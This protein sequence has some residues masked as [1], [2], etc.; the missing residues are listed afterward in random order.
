MKLLS[1]L[2]LGLLG[3]TCAQQFGESSQV[4]AATT[5]T[6]SSFLDDVN[7][8]LAQIESGEVTVG[9]SQGPAGIARMRGAAVP[10]PIL[11]QFAG[12]KLP[13]GIQLSDFAGGPNGF[14]TQAFLKALQAALRKQAEQQRLR[15]QQLAAQRQRE[16]LAA[17]AAKE[18]AEE[19]ARLKA[20]QEAKRLAAE[21]AA[22]EAEQAAAEEAARE[23][24]KQAAAEEAARQAAQ[25]A[26][27]AEAKRVA[28][29]KEQARQE[30]LREAAR[31]RA[32]EQA[33]AK[34]AEQAAREAA[35][36]AE[37]DAAMEAAGAS[38]LSD[39]I[40]S[41]M[42]DEEF[43]GS[44]SGRPNQGNSDGS[45][46]SANAGRPNATNSNSAGVRD[47]M[48]NTVDNG[49]NVLSEQDQRFNSCRVCDKMTA[50]ECASQSLTQCGPT[51]DNLTDN[52]VC[53]LTLDSRLNKDGT[54]TTL[55]TSQCA[56]PSTCEAAVKQNFGPTTSDR[57]F[58]Q[59]KKSSALN[60]RW[61]TS[62]CSFCQKLSHE[63]GSGNTD[64]FE[65]ST[66]VFA[67]ITEAQLLADPAAQGTWSTSNP[68][69]QLHNDATYKYEV[70]SG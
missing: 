69:G 13:P 9:E 43:F 14:R 32:R 63:N 20:E 27:Q 2:T 40:A 68:M 36:A 65:T 21:Q 66:E 44:S 12:R 57:R 15:Q 1:G 61:N 70:I 55:Y 11:Q 24:A 18:A 31:Q 29:A 6:D 22:R 34:A 3:L 51:Q 17:K 8:V 19:A 26:A 58:D 52:R 56:I 62:S 30:A 45:V 16:A 42:T 37:I 48:G 47:F 5:T 64:I 60:R 41:I 28:A 35:Q 50:S 39:S 53:M 7:A 59:C 10:D 67:G 49:G 25:A 4:S 23:A 54:T 46:A 38:I 33:A